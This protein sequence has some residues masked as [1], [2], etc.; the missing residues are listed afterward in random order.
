M[1]ST[2]LVATIWATRAKPRVPIAKLC[3]VSRNIGTPTASAIRPAAAMPAGSAAANGQRAS[4]ASR[5]A[6]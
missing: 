6:V 2:Q 1:N 4:V 5:A 3:S